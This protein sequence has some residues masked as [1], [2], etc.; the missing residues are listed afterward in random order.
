MIFP[1]GR[2]NSRQ[3]VGKSASHR[4]K[5]GLSQYF[6]MDWQVEAAAEIL[7]SKCRRQRIGSAIREGTMHCVFLI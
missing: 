7:A 3:G 4:R 5:C 1:A 2:E 6:G